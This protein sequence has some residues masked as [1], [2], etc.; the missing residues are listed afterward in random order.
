MPDPILDE[1]NL[2]TL[3]EI[4][5]HTIEDE[6]FL[7]TP[8]LAYLRAHCLVDF[9]G[10]ALSRFT[11]L[12]AP[13]VGGSYARGD[14]FNV[15][16]RQTLA[17]AQFFP[18][19]YEVSIPEYLEDL[20]VFNKG[21]LAVFSLIDTDLANA[22][23]TISAIVAV[24]MS[25]HGQTSGSG[26]V[27]NRPKDINGWIEAVN[28]GITPGWD[29]SFFTTYGSATR[30]A[31]IGSKFNSTP[32]FVGTAAGATAPIT[33]QVLEETY[34][35]A[36][37]GREEPNLGVTNKAAYAYIKERIQPQQRFAQERD[38][39]FGVSGMKMNAAM[40][41]KD[42]YFPSLRYG[43]N[44]PDIGNWLTS[45]F[46][47][48][49]TVGTGSNLPTSTTINVGEVFSWFNTKKWMVRIS[50]SALYGFGFTGFKPA[51][52]NTKVVGQILAALN[53]ECVAPRLQKQIYG[54]GG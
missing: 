54:I 3:N 16:K 35:D 42:D 14:S 21:P 48:P 8:F 46:S 27:G 30:N 20:E 12:Y 17:G 2:T 43:Q 32:F 18:K 53:L 47:S 28:D 52:D 1:I 10:G 23:H 22:M 26:V 13:M 6:F 37:I 5:P 39:Y 9:K 38:P 33:Y 49:S 45:T 11:F 50:N 51:Q 19:F 36:S 44:D 41:L 25:L 34:Q 40:I 31:V 15:N 7:D 4:Y 24:A 29:G